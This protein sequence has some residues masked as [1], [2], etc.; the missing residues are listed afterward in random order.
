MLIRH[1]HLVNPILDLQ[2]QDLQVLHDIVHRVCWAVL[3]VLLSEEQRAFSQLLDDHFACADQLGV[4]E[5]DF[6]AD[7]EEARLE[8]DVG[9]VSDV[10]GDERG[11]AV[12]SVLAFSDFL[13]DV[14]DGVLNEALAVFDLDGCVVFVEDVLVEGAH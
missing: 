4:L 1:L 12:D 6:S 8:V 11:E 9:H 13:D 2:R 7:L 3:V 14:L 10:I 5:L